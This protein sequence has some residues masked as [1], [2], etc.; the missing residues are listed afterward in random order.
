MSSAEQDR[1]FFLQ[2][3]GSAIED[4]I[5]IRQVAD[6]VRQISPPEEEAYRYILYIESLL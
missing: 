3:P 6:T 4:I 1:M 2:L 5:S